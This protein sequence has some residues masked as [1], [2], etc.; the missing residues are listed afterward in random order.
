MWRRNMTAKKHEND[1]T[2]A[3][4]PTDVG[5]QEPDTCRLHAVQFALELHKSLG[6]SAEEIV[7]ESA[8]FES[9]LRDGAART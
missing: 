1:K 5:G 7:K 9:Y 8:V 4:K 3:A 2:D 6:K